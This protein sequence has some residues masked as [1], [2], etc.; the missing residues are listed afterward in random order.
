MTKISGI[1]LLLLVCTQVKA[2]INQECNNEVKTILVAKPSGNY[3]IDRE[4]ILNALD[5]VNE[6]DTLQFS[7]GTYLLSKKIQININSIT[8]K[9]DSLKTIIRGCNPEKFTEPLYGLLNCGGFEL[10]GQNQTVENF[11]FE[12][13][14]HGIMI[15]CCLPDNM[16][17]LENGTNIKKQQLGG[18]L[19]QNNIFRFN[20][21]GIRVIG[22]N[23]RKVVIR[24]NIFQ[25]NF[26]GLTLNGSNVSVKGN[27]F[28]A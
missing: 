9:G 14:W 26:H 12:Y 11:I 3:T 23:P 4:L 18:H 5:K 19:I 15:G 27:R 20:S 6:G 8:L 1:L 24:D 22:I 13:T 16:Q 25:D 10:I 17:Q 28:D 2:Y 7:P 21:T